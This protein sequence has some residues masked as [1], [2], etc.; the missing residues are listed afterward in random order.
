M[1]SITE[2]VKE[3][4]RQSIQIIATAASNITKEE[5]DNIPTYLYSK[6]DAKFVQGISVIFDTE[7][8]EPLYW[9]GAELF[10]LKIKE[11]E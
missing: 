11:D 3:V 6:S 10:K 5:L 4:N 9:M 8:E 1:L 2:V 7:Y